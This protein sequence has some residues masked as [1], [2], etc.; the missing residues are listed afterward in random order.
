[1]NIKQEYNNRV[2]NIWILNIFSPTKTKIPVRDFSEIFTK[3]KI[4]VL[5]RH[6]NDHNLATVIYLV[7]AWNSYKHERIVRDTSKSLNRVLLAVV[8]IPSK[9][10]REIV[11]ASSSSRSKSARATEPDRSANFR[12]PWNSPAGWILWRSDGR[13]DASD[14]H[15]H[16]LYRRAVRR[17]RATAL[18]L[19]R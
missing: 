11:I 19:S 18:K 13:R 2:F 3:L 6:R 9:H 5:I 8:K 10:R 4:L 14:A 15:L 7:G 12:F 16:C 17:V 1:M